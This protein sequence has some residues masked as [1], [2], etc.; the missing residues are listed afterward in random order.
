MNKTD[1][2]AKLVTKIQ[3]AISDYVYEAED[4]Y[5][6]A[7]ISVS[8]ADGRTAVPEI[9]SYSSFCIDDDDTDNEEEENHGGDS[10]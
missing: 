6:S 7:L 3:D 9:I 10:I 5:F 1:R 8:A 4:C 2:L